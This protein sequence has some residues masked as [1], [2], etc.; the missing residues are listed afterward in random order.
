MALPYTAL[1]TVA[2]VRRALMGAGGSLGDALQDT[3]DDVYVGTEEA[4]ED[5]TSDIER[6]VNRELIVRDQTLRFKMK[7]WKTRPGHENSDED[8]LIGAWARQF[9]VVQVQSVDGQTAW[10]SEITAQEYSFGGQ[11]LTYDPDSALVTEPPFKIQ[12]FAGYRR[13]D[14]VL[15]GAGENE[16]NLPTSTGEDLDGLTVLPDQ[17]PGLVRRVAI[18][19]VVSEMRQQYEALVG[20]ASRTKRMDQMTVESRRAGA[21][22]YLP[23]SM[24][25]RQ[26]E[27]AKLDGLR[28]INA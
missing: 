22:L 19:L 11:L 17:L 3:A 9:P 23:G 24:T 12:A 6:Y 27:L 16:T 4:I 14:Q 25:N 28:W 2:E 26:K 20:V 10:A 15:S 1:I 18:R 13:R 7:D 21:A 8:L 5:A